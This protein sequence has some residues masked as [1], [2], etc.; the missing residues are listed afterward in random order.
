MTQLCLVPVDDHK[1]GASLPRA[2]VLGWQA[3]IPGREP[4]TPSV[5]AL[6]NA[7]F[8]TSG[9][10]ALYHSLLALDLPPGTSVLVPT[11]HCPTM[12][13]PVLRAGLV[14]TFY[15]IGE[16]GL[17]IHETLSHNAG[18]MVV[19]H[20]FGIA[21]S[22]SAERAWCDQ[23]R[24]AL[25]EDCAHSLF[26]M[27]GDRPIGTWGDIST[28][29][30]SKFLPIPEGGVIASGRRQL[31]PLALGR[32]TARAQVKGAFDVIEVSAR[33]RHLRGITTLMSPVFAFR[34]RR[35]IAEASAATVPTAASMFAACDM[36]RVELQQLWVSRQIARWLPRGRIVSRRRENFQIYRRHFEGIEGGKALFPLLSESAVP[37]VF[38]LWLDNADAIYAELRRLEAP[39]FRWDRIWPGTPAILGDHGRLWSGHVL[40]L[41]CHQDLSSRDIEAVARTILMLLS[42]TKKM[43][44]GQG[45]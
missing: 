37:Y 30:L 29:S 41:L 26:G 3:L 18:A 44:Q 11:Y 42:S 28:A 43:S 39:V 35:R 2:P 19:A 13:A 14:P 22:L 16:D 36:D 34:Q 7:Q 9:R 10:A 20:F 6:S 33:F 45:R 32:Q 15:G 25:I 5:D 21:R 24:V 38:P 4:D 23:H 31:K 40:Q 17:P 1:I 12:V 27:A 8:T